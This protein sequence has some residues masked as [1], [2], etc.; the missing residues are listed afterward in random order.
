MANRL[1]GN[2]A[3][4][5]QRTITKRNMRAFETNKTNANTQ[6]ATRMKTASDATKE[7]LLKKQKKNRREADDSGN[8]QTDRS[9]MR[10]PWKRIVLVLVALSRA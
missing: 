1:W 9:I 2:Q 5:A 4:K 7:S 8:G 3:Q 6:E 10:L